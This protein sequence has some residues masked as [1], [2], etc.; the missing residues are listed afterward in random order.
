MVVVEREIM[1]ARSVLKKIAE[2][3][4]LRAAIETY[5][6][7]QEYRRH[8]MA[9]LLDYIY[10]IVR[11]RIRNLEHLEPLEEKI[12]KVR[13]SMPRRLRELSRIAGMRQMLADNVE[14]M[15][16]LDSRPHPV[17]RGLY[18]PGH[19]MYDF[20]VR[21]LA[22]DRQR[23]SH[24]QQVKVCADCKKVY[25]GIAVNPSGSALRD[26]RRRSERKRP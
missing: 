25:R 12:A 8:Q 23:F 15:E 22:A 21:C 1:E 10:D 5:P 24:C 16:R 26:M 13:R 18:E 17:V 6:H 3:E 11:G 2:D 9:S 4:D 7:P 20:A 19:T 14:L